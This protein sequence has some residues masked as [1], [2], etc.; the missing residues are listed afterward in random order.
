MEGLVAVAG[1]CCS[2]AAHATQGR[3]DGERKESV[4]A[5]LDARKDG[6]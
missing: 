6:R 1:F 4:N 5:R 3:K 2:S